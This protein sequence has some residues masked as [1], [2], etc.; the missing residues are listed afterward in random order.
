LDCVIGQMN[1]DLIQ[2]GFFQVVRLATCP[3]VRLFEHKALAIM[4]NQ[5]PL[6]Y[7]KFSVPEQD[8]LLYVLLYDKS[9]VLN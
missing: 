2:I 6:P 3:N 8:W 7:V 1:V 9:F 4:G 5:H